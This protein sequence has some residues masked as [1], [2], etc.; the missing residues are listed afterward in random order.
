MNHDKHSKPVAIVT[1]GGTGIGAAMAAQLRDAG[2]EVAISGGRP[3]LLEETAAATGAFPNALDM[4]DNHGT[5]E[6]VSTVMEKSAGWTGWSLMLPWPTPDG[7]RTPLTRAG[8]RCTRQTSSA[9]RA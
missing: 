8:G 2:W 7:L 3:H 5:D 1:G 6:L 4:T 9:Q